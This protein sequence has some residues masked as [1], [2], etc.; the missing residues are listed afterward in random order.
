MTITYQ[1]HGNQSSVTNAADGIALHKQNKKALI[2]YSH[3]FKNSLN[4]NHNTNNVFFSISATYIGITEFK[5][6]QKGNN[7]PIASLVRFD[8]SSVSHTK[9]KKLSK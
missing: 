7:H 6:Q 8:S 2:A 4:N 3:L 9:T 5:I 1:P